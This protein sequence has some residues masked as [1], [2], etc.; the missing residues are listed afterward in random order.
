M[1]E[2]CNL[3]PEQVDEYFEALHETLSAGPCPGIEV[4]VAIRWE[5]TDAS[6]WILRAFPD[7]PGSAELEDGPPAEDV[8]CSV[9]CTLAVL[10]DLATGRKR[11]MPALL[12]GQIKVS[13]DRSVFRTGWALIEVM[14]Q[15]AGSFKTRE[16]EEPASGD[17]GRLRV[18][19]RGVSIVA[20]TNESFAVYHIE[21]FEAHTRWMV[22]HRWSEL[23]ALARRIAKLTAS[24]LTRVPTLP[25]KLDFT[26]SL[27]PRFLEMRSR[28]MM[29][30]LSRLLEALPTSM[31]DSTG[32]VA[33]R[34]F[35]SISEDP[36]ASEEPHVLF[37]S[38]EESVRL[39]S[40][41]RLLP[42][43]LS[44]HAARGRL[45][46]G[47]TRRGAASFRTVIAPRE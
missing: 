4:P 13:G 15:V 38:A 40:R 26:S 33:I 21:V 20:D 14:Q 5:L 18:E 19:V 2:F 32:P 23:R 43:S 24:S 28:L 25:K 8:D 29:T 3:G 22:T 7:A 39:P 9:R 16:V 27:E 30:Y 36:L 11:P 34:K 6:S 17:S 37:P 12:R 42:L 46:A 35:L 1:E 31:V 45:P 44:L 10:L 47:K 41:R